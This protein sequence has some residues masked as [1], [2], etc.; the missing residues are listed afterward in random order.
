MQNVK[1][2]G[3]ILMIVNAVFFTINAAFMPYVPVPL[4]NLVCGIASLFGFVAAWQMYN[5]E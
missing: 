3:M 4:I 2:L 1:K 5:Q